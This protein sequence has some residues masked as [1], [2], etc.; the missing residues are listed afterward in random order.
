MRNTACA[1]GCSRLHIDPADLRISD[2][3]RF[4]NEHA[5][6]SRPVAVSFETRC[7]VA[8][9]NFDIIDPCAIVTCWRSLIFSE[10][11]DPSER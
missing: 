9:Q 5:L 6:G 11:V 7:P 10:Q 2:R 3:V 1:L 4:D 8:L